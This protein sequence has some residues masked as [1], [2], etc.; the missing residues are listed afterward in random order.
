MTSLNK[1]RY[2]PKII[3]ITVI[4]FVLMAWLLVLFFSRYAYQKGLRA[5]ELE[6]Y[7][8]A[9]V[10]LARA[11]EILPAGLASVL[12]PRDLFRIHTALGKT[13]YQQAMI[14]ADQSAV[15]MDRR[16][17]LESAYQL[18]KKGHNYLK[19]A[20]AHDPLSYRT[21]FWYAKVTDKLAVLHSYF[22]PG[23]SSITY[24]ALPLFQKA[25]LLRPSGI[26]VRYELANYFHRHRMP[27]ELQQVVKNIGTI[28]PSAHAYLKKQV[29]FDPDVRAVFRQGCL[30]ALATDTTPRKT[31]SIL[32][33]M[34]MEDGDVNAAIEYYQK[35]MA[36]QAHTN[37]AYTYRYLAGLYLKQK[38]MDKSFELFLKALG[39]SGNLKK[40]YTA[41]YNQFRAEKL[42][43]EF[44]N[45]ARYVK[46][47][48]RHSPVGEMIMVR[49]FM[50]MGQLEVAKARLERI[51]DKKPTA[52]AWY[53]MATLAEKQK[54]WNTMEIAS[55]RATVL[56]SSN[57]H[58]HYY[59]C[60][61][62]QRMG[63]HE[64]A[65]TAITHA[66]ETVKKKSVGYYNHRAWIR[67]TLK[68]YSGAIEDWQQCLELK[69]DTSGYY[70]NIARAYHQ[71]KM[72]TDALNYA[73]RALEI[74]PKNKTYQN[75]ILK[76]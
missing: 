7:D 14:L 68:N 51:I 45:F 18:F 76:F 61:A 30:L 43:D 69:P 2:N 12:A 28:Y 32:S 74:D 65:E 44:I 33:S 25:A 6:H 36:Y 60:R 39:R 72:E 3:V 67:W 58:Y 9:A 22:N 42:F 31:L 11:E 38:D 37:A 57:S 8:E 46:E 52:H 73:Q 17:S 1:F 23:V 10:H 26:T 19:A 21:A 27:Q 5:H 54:D 20:V 4:Y 55:Q 34:A 63:K 49:C 40:E 13:L 66:I 16:R 62:L 29:W 41:I 75:W 48:R 47:K 56:D 64:Q 70:F 24:D 15:G 53:L 35:S 50:D 59:F 71:Q